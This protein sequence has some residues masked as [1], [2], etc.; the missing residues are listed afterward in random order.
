[1]DRVALPL[2]RGGL[3]EQPANHIEFRLGHGRGT[4]LLPSAAERMRGKSNR[5]PCPFPVGGGF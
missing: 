2:S 4:L 1:M 3:L 5:H